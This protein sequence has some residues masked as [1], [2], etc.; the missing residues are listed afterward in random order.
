MTTVNVLVAV[1]VGQALNQIV[2]TGNA[3]IGEYVYM[4]DTTGYSG[5][6]EGTDELTTTVTVGGTLIWQTVSIDPSQ[7]VT[8]T[9]FSGQAIPSVVNP[10]QYPQ[11]SGAVWGGSVN[12]TTQ[13]SEQYTIGL[14][15]NGGT[16]AWFDPFIVSNAPV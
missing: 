7:T 14:L 3:N 1:N 2:N 15:L 4:A 16:H 5:S 13:G 10:V 12:S 11:Y 9:G 8:I 6:G